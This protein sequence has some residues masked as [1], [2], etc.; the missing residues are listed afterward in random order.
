LNLCSK[1]DILVI[2]TLLQHFYQQEAPMVSK[3]LALALLTV[4]TVA[5]GQVRLETHIDINQPRLDYVRTIDIEPVLDKGQSV[6]VFADHVG[7][8]TAHLLDQDDN[9]VTV[10]YT[11]EYKDSDNDAYRVIANPTL[12]TKLGKSGQL[13]IGYDNSVVQESEYI[14]VEITAH[15]AK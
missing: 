5:Q 12:V 11:V 14:K 1:S 7:R 9:K 15:E 6:E 4:G 3:H 13:T 2:I 8:V 10:M